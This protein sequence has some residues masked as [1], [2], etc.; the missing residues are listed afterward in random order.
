VG[1]DQSQREPASDLQLFEDMLQVDLD[2]TRG[3]PEVTG[4]IAIGI[5][6][7]DQ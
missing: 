2:R 5:S 6:L 3:D 7:G 1:D 4:D